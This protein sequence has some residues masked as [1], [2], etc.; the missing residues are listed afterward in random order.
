MPSD[1]PT[2]HPRPPH[3]PGGGDHAAPAGRGRV[4]RGPRVVLRPWRHTDIEP[5]VAM[6]A[7]P[8][9]MRHF[10]APL[11]RA[12]A[13]E[14]ARRIDDHIRRLGWGLWALEVPPS[15]PF[16][17]F[18]GLA[19]VNG[20]LPFAPAVEV[21]WR[22]A[23][24]FWGRGWATEGARLALRF[25]AEELGLAEVVAYT[26]VTNR[27]SAAVMERLGMRLRMRFEH[28]LVPEGHPLRT[29]EL[30]VVDPAGVEPPGAPED[31]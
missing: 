3:H 18:V 25:A 5:F 4:L 26:A 17:G 19:T 12:A 22:L 9:V 16:A 10:P 30:R 1:R 20:P 23:R 2:G 28:P 14:L 13:T 29:H 6:G 7:D 15:V 24:P 27:R 11:D 21:G 8:E 31:R